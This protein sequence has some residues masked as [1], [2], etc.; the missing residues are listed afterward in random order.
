M[1]NTRAGAGA[2][3]QPP[4]PPPPPTMEELVLMQTQLMQTMA[5]SMAMMQQ[6]QQNQQHQAPVRDR[7]VEFMKGNPPK[8]THASNPLQAD[9]WLKAVERQLNIAQCTD[10]E[11]VLYASGQLEGAAL[12]WWDAYQVGVPN[13]DQITWQQFRDSF[14]SH[15]VPAGLMKL[16]MKEF[17]DL[18]QEEMSVTAYRDKFLE[19]AHYAPEDVST[20]RKR[21]AR[22]RDGLQ[23][24]I[25]LQMMCITFPNFGEL[26]DGALMIE[27]KRLEIEEK[28]RKFMGQ[29]SGSST[30][31]RFNPQPSGQLGNQQ[32]F[33]GQSGLLNRNQ[34]P[35][36]PQYPPQQQQ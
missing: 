21:Q 11:K 24:A 8:F 28:K 19:L 23:D 9:D 7:R 16:K 34:F 13:R 15:H 31:P 10:R 14:R 27:H 26:V 36:R 3:N 25:Q 30:R 6:N 17:R 5:Q 35:Q 12:D 22:F 1:V 18:T 20:D 33:Q 32:R 29:Q 2:S 4:P